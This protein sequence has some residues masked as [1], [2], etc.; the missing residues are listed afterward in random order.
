MSPGPEILARAVDGFV[1]EWWWEPGLGPEAVAG[2]LDAE[3]TPG[4]VR[5]ASLDRLGAV[6]HRSGHPEPIRLVWEL[7]GELVLAEVAGPSLQPSVEGALQELGPP[8]AV[9]EHGRGPHPGAQ[10]LVHLD[11][12]LTIFDG[13]NRGITHLWLFR[14]TDLDGYISGLSATQNVRRAR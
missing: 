7:D 11:R 3:M 1:T 13:F 14:P 6:A 12:G 2:A 4:P 8:S 5:L 10:Q 9:L